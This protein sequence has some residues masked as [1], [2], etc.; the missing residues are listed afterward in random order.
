V[1]DNTSEFIKSIDLFEGLSNRDLSTIAA[2]LKR[3]DFP[4]GKPV[5]NEGEGGVGF[6][7]IETGTATVRQG[8]REV[9]KIGPG[10]YFGEI[11]LLAGSNRSA[12]IVADG[13]LSCLGMTAWDF[14]PMVRS[15]P[16]IALKLL[17]KMAHQ[18]AG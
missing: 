15:H 11:A 18:L 9:A 5:V 17:E 2:T 6:F 10:S 1:A 4:A 7:I 14:K 12:S 13:D 16:S 3:R 8:D